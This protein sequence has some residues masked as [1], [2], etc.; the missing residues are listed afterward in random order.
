MKFIT[1]I[2]AFDV[3]ENVAI[4]ALVREYPDYDEGPSE[5]VLSVVTSIRS[6]GELDPR[7]WLRSVLIALLERT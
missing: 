2:H 1:S 3:L 6:E 7:E 5:V 4:K